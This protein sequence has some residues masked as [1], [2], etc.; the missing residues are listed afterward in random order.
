MSAWMMATDYT[1]KLGGNYFI[2][3]ESLITYDDATLFTLTR[4]ENDGRLGIDCDIYDV[5]GNKI[6]TIRHGTI[7]DVDRNRYDFYHGADCKRVYDAES[8]RVILEIRRRLPDAE[9]GVTV[10][11]YLPESGFLLEADTDEIKLP[12]V[13]ARIVGN[14]LRNLKHGIVIGKASGGGGICFSKPSKKK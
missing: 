9:L 13:N 2:N 4:R 6:A 3:C 5:K 8:E 7:V 14:I 1:V 11:M 12:A 10:R